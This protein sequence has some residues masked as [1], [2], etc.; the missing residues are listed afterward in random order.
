[1]LFGLRYMCSKGLLFLLLNNNESILISAIDTEA[2]SA[3][4]TMSGVAGCSVILPFSKP[5]G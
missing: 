2:I 4:E 5:R 3:C 1:M